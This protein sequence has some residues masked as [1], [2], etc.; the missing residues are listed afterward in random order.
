MENNSNNSSTNRI[1]KVKISIGSSKLFEEWSHGEVK[2]PET[3]NYK[4]FRPEKQGL[5]CEEIFGPVKNYT[6]PKCGKKH[7]RTEEG[8]KCISCNDWIVSASHVRRR[9]MGHIKLEAPI[10]HIWYSKV[11]YSMIRLLLGIKND[12]LERVIYFKAHIV[13][14]VGGLKSIKERQIIKLEEAPKIYSKILKEILES[15]KLKDGERKL[16]EKEL[17]ELVIKANY[18]TSMREYGIDFYKYNNFVSKHSKVVIDSGAKAVKELLLKLNLVNEKKRIKEKIEKEQSEKSVVNNK[19]YRELKIVSSFII[20]KQKPEDMII[21]V[22]PVIPPGLRPIIQLDGGRHSTVDVNELYRRIIIRNNRLKDWIKVDAPELI[23]YNEKRM[24]QEA[25]DAL[26]D[27]QRKE[28]AVL[29]K[30]GRPYKSLADNLKGKQ[31]RFRQNL[32]GKRV[33][34]SGRSVIVVGPDLK[35]NEVGLPREMVLKIFEHNIINQL[36]VNNVAINIKQ[37]KKMIDEREE[38]IWKYVEKAIENNPVLLNRAPTLHRLSIQAFYPRLTRGKAIQLHPLVTPPF[39]ADFDGDQMAVHVLLSKEAKE[40]ARMLMNNILGPKDGYLVLTPSQDMVLGLYFLTKYNSQKFDFKKERPMVFANKKEALIAYQ[41]GVVSLQEPI[42][43]YIKFHSKK[44][45]QEIKEGY[46]YVVTTIGRLKL[47][48]IIPD[49]FPYVNEVTKENLKT[50][51]NKYLLKSLDDVKNIDIDL[52]PFRKNHISNLIE[53]I[54]EKNKENVG[55][56]LDEIKDLGFYYSTISGSSISVNDIVNLSSKEKIISDSN[57]KVKLL[58][59]YKNEGFLTDDQRY[60]QVLQVWKQAKKEIQLELETILNSDKDNALF[61]MMDSGA[62]GNISNFVQLAGMRGIMSKPTHVYA[63]LKKQNI[64]V[65][66]EEEIPIKSSFKSGLSSF[67]FYISTNGARKGLS[68]TATKTASSGYLTRRLVDA[69]QD[70]KIVE[71]D[72]KT[73]DAIAISAIKYSLD[74]TIIESLERRLIGKYTLKDV[75]D[76]NNN[77]ILKKNTMISKEKAFEIENVGITKVEIRTILS[78]KSKHGICSKCYG[79]DLATGNDVTIGEAVGIIAAQSIGEPGTQL[80]MRTFHTGGVADANDITQGFSRLT[81]LVDANQNPKG[82][83]EI[84]AVNGTIKSI[85][86]IEKDN[87]VDHQQITIELEDGTINEVDISLFEKLQVKIGDEVKAGDKLTQGS[88][89]LDELLE[90]SSPEKVQNYL[91][92]ELQKIY[93]IQGLHISDKYMEIVIRQMLSKVRIL[94][95]GDSEF[96]IGQI[97]SKD[98]F[99]EICNELSKVNKIS[100]TME[101]VIFGVKQLPLFSESFLSAASYQ[102]TTEI[103]MHA[104]IEAREDNLHGIKE[105]VILG[106]IIPVGT[107]LRNPHGKYDFLKN[108]HSK[109]EEELLEDATELNFVEDIDNS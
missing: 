28:N 3:I 24:L 14:D 87:V 73:N 60:L 10:A 84:S 90:V 47:N 76:K 35:L 107:G 34:Y 86:I 97:V 7:K 57:E 66:T 27:N 30:D 56:F 17:E 40:E 16:I 82:V 42:L 33:D 64:L 103:L 58:Q 85:K 62:R 61:M 70:V 43:M 32:L 108:L 21:D 36:I 25:V 89:K 88:I 95:E 9:N 74:N 83:A 37:A 39:N 98:K 5:F 6:C 4:S 105:N 1:S 71:D 100:P 18:D 11:D 69:I 45:G 23:I 8:K 104:A 26:F 101:R 46:K 12:D 63:A 31:G 49:G 75:V 91:L 79:M 29:T 38:K 93:T 48:I 96:Y 50:L 19:L 68:D 80:T 78:C 81:E 55:N 92:K 41:N 102:R 52:K 99:E 59:N 94:S 72:C 54:Y 106:N 53:E 2:K 20:S 109:E 67:E 13:V 15:N 22:I 51:P 65:R 77:V 44:F